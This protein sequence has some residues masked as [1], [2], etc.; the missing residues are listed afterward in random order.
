M[1]VSESILTAEE[2]VPE[3]GWSGFVDGIIGDIG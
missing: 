1:M 3:V 2:K